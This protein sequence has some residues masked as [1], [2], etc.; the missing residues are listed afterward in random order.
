MEQAHDIL[1]IVTREHELHVFDHVNVGVAVDVK[2]DLYVVVAKDA[3]KRPAKEVAKELRALQY[4]ALRGRLETEHLTGGTIT[5]TSMI[6]RGIHRFQPIPYPEQAA[7]VGIADVE[8]GTSRAALVLVFD[9]RVANGTRA[10]EFLATIA[11]ELG[12]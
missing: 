2:G 6:G 12:A 4:L 1:E 8:P 5:V 7:I 11:D 9:H 10:A 3:D